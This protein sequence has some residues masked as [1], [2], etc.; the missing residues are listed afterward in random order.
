MTPSW[1]IFIQ[2]SKYVVLIALL[3]QQWLRERLSLL[4]PAYIGCLVPAELLSALFSP[5]CM[6]QANGCWP[7]V[8]KFLALLLKPRTVYRFSLQSSIC[9]CRIQYQTSSDFRRASKI[10][11]SDL[12]SPCLP[13]PMEQPGSHWTDFYET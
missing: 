2:L 11:K 9:H 4:R 6:L 8:R 13:A 7:L 5:T 10:T 12:A 3:R 1:S